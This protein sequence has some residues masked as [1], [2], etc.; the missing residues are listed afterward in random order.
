MAGCFRYGTGLR[1]P[2]SGP[3]GSAWPMQSWPRPDTLV[4]WR[5]DPLVEVCPV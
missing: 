3:Q 1:P 2:A 5:L 4:V